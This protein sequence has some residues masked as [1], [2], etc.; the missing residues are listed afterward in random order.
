[1][2]IAFERFGNDYTIRSETLITTSISDQIYEAVQSGNFQSLVT[3]S[4]QADLTLLGEAL[5]DLHTSG[6]IELFEFLRRIDWV[7][8]EAK[9]KTRWNVAIE[10]AVGQ[11]RSDPK[12]TICWFHDILDGAR[13]ADVHLL[14]K[15]F[16]KWTE[17]NADC[18]A[19]VR[20][21]I[22]ACERD[23]ELVHAFLAN[24]AKHNAAA[25]LETALDWSQSA[26]TQTRHQAIISLSAIVRAGGDA[27][28]IYRTLINLMEKGS[29]VDQVSAVTAANRILGNSSEPLQPLVGAL[30]LLA[31]N[32]SQSVRHQLIDGLARSGGYPQSLKEKVYGLFPASNEAP[33]TLGLIDLA[34]SELDLNS[35]FQLVCELTTSLL[36][37]DG[38]DPTKLED[39]DIFVGKLQSAPAA[40]VCRYL[41]HW[42]LAG[43]QV[44]CSQLNDIF[45][46][47]DKSVYAFDLPSSEL[48]VADVFYL[49][50][51]IYAYLFFCHGPA[52]SLLTTCL[53]ALPLEDRKRLEIDIASFWLRN[54]PGDL[55]LFEQYAKIHPTRG[56]KASIERM[57]NAVDAYREPLQQ[58]KLNKAFHPSPLERRVQAEVRREQDAEASKM[59][60]EKSVFMSIF[61]TSTLLY[62]RAAISRIVDSGGSS[63]R[64]V[65]S[66]KSFETSTA[67]P[68][69]DV[70]YP[71]RLSYLMFRF[72]NEKR[73]N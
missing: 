29:E 30:E 40:V 48:S 55:E 63:S 17:T 4:D 47:I 59:M 21:V 71:A 35:D 7:A 12:T 46:P 8:L 56:L 22:A 51:K 27:D 18:L 32:P 26:E 24:W 41:V 73:P 14:F 50:R 36:L 19:E 37:Q 10:V 67:L 6:S 62:G 68:R 64:Q 43:D 72:R 70:L 66:M 65:I 52:V 42:L 57:S 33:N 9:Y 45:P 61:P 15:S 3:S 28:A 11:V 44:I 13:Q 23:S 38:E 58:L 1:L 60:K 31:Q 2:S 54:F 25:A 53:M 49:T 20:D 69:M 34:L 39:L 16:E 5:A